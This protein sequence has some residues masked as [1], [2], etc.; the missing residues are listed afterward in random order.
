MNWEQLRAILWLRW[1]LTKNRFLR[2]GSFNAGLTI[3]IGAMLLMTSVGVTVLGLV[4]GA[5]GL[6]HQAPQILLLVWDGI[7]LMFL[8]FWLSGLLVELQRSESIDLTK[9]LHLPVTLPQVFGFN[10]LASHFTPSIVVLLPGM[11]GLWAGLL[12]GSGLR[13]ALLLPVIL[14]F[15]FMLTAWTYCLRGWLAALMVNKRRRR[16]VMV[17]VTV[18]FVLVFQIPNL[19]VNTSLLGKQRTRTVSERGT[20]PFENKVKEPQHSDAN[21]ALPEKLMAAHIVIPPGWVGYAAMALRQGNPWPGVGAAAV[22]GLIGAL[23]LRRAY[24]MTLRFY[25]GA[26]GE[27]PVQARIPGNIRSRRPLLVGQQLPFL[28]DDTA[29]L[30][31]A[32]FRSL[33]RAPELKLALIMPIVAGAA[34]SATLFRHSGHPIPSFLTPL[35]ATTAAVIAP[36]SLAPIMSNVFGLDRNG[37][38]ALVL[39]PTRRDRIL[40]G[41]NLAFLPY[42]GGIGLV[43]LLL[44]SFVLHLGVAGFI[45]GLLQ[46]LMAFMLFSL[47]CNLVAILAPYKTASGTLQARKPKPIVFLAAFITLLT[48]PVVM[49]PILIPP[50]LQALF[51]FQG[52]LPWLPINLL[53]SSAMLVAIAALYRVVLPVEGRLLH[54]REQ[55]ILREVTEELE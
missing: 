30:G 9:L 34:L 5:F 42:A 2:A 38:C 47:V 48:L 17:W 43:F 26:E 8:V 33:L 45:T 53:A 28:P 13:M 51:S 18:S 31:L 3:V 23:G 25:Q 39:L 19:L 49:T 55:T 32:T 6:A 22:S 10:Y 29:A 1:R 54:R 7:L 14:G 44:A 15:I 36:F 52:W 27:P 12:Y 35:V 20:P 24:R 16:A 37:F 21:L 46:V 4:L 11:L 41:K 40:L 50:A